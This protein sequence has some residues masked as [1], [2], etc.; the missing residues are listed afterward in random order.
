MLDLSKDLLLIGEYVPHGH[1]YLWQTELVTLHALSDGLIALAY[2]AIP[3]AIVYLIRER[4]DLP[5]KNILLLFGAFII[6]CG[7]THLMAVFTLWY[8]IYWISGTLKALT[9]LISI[10]TVIE[11]V[12]LLPTI[13]ALPSPA[14]LEATNQQLSLEITQRRQAEAEVRRVNQELEKRVKERTEELEKSRKFVQ[15]ITDNSTN[16]LYLHQ[17]QEEKLIYISRAVEKLLGYSP[18]ELTASNQ[19]HIEWMV[20]QDDQKAKYDY[21]KKLNTLRDGEVLEI[22][23]RVKDKQNQ[24]RWICSSSTVFSRNE[25]GEVLEI[26]GTATDV[27]ARKKAEDNLHKMNTRLRRWI[28][29]LEERNQ[30]MELLAEMNDFLQSCVNME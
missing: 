23:Y 25:K 1:C 27:T 28:D 10:Y 12:P 24:W 4:R 7:T 3:F 2:Y 22:E 11:L 9:A 18:E 17:A 20:H 8:P 15:K 5:F 14:Q 21:N 26:L 19:G 30:E 13:L 16:V 29:E 6:T